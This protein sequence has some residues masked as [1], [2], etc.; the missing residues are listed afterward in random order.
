[1]AATARGR[2]DTVPDPPPRYD[3][4]LPRVPDLDPSLHPRGM[5][6]CGSVPSIHIAIISV[7]LEGTPQEIGPAAR[8]VRP[9]GTGGPPNLDSDVV[10]PCRFASPLSQ[11]TLVQMGRS[12]RVQT[13]GGRRLRQDRGG[14]GGVGMASRGLAGPAVGSELLEFTAGGATFNE[15]VAPV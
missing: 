13:Q 7:H 3:L 4:S 2:L 10:K 14:R 8:P 1:M 5:S 9:R 12:I 6:R 11:P 15:S